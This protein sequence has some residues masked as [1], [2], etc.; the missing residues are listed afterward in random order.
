MTILLKNDDMK[1]KNIVLAFSNIVT[2]KKLKID[3]FMPNFRMIWS[4]KLSK[5]RL[6]IY[7]NLSKIIH[8][9]WDFLIASL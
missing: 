8:Y 4:I 7:I 9:V 1:G 5:P 6:G 3:G 2:W